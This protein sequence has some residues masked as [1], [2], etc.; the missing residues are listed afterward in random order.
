[1]FGP[2][3]YLEI[4]FKK[5]KADQYSVAS[6]AN[7]NIFCSY[8][9][10]VVSWFSGGLCV[11]CVRVCVCFCFVFAELPGRGLNM[12]AKLSNP[13]MAKYK[14]TLPSFFFLFVPPSRSV[15]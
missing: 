6:E 14:A 8:T 12:K 11:W 5:R 3:K 13:S 1:M 9:E 2:E 4:V 7:E 10:P 15:T